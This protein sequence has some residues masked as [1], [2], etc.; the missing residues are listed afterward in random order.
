LTFLHFQQ[1]YPASKCFFAIFVVNCTMHSPDPIQETLFTLIKS[2][3][4]AHVSF[5][6][7]LSELLGIS[8]DSAYRRIRGEKELSLDELKKISDYYHISLDT[9]FNVSSDNI[10]FNSIA[11]GKE[12]YTLQEWLRIIL[13]EI[14]NIQVCKQKEIIY[15]AKD[16]PIFH[17]FEFPDLFAFKSY[18][19]NKVL[20]SAPGYEQMQFRFDFP[21]EILNMGKQ[22]LSI[23]NKVPTIELWNEETF[24]SLIRQIDFCYICN[25]FSS[26][27]DA[28]RVIDST[29]EMIKHLS[30]QAETGFRYMHGTLPEG[31]E[32]NFKL[33]CN[34]VL[35]GD[36]TIFVAKEGHLK[37]FLTYN[38]INLLVTENERFCRQVEYSLR[39]L[40]KKSTLISGTSEKERNRFFHLLQEKIN[41][42]RERIR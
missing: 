36:N 29:E 4:P 14:R 26:K 3:L 30:L 12:G 15:S 22:I 6:H 37:T 41:T 18:F 33:F 25:Y 39:T 2:R 9:L 7:E 21:E 19:W 28:L 27:E 35:L 32:G 34:E 38:V 5:V 16:I 23:Y 13:D 11:I 10:L 1:K 31:I 24:N 40:T 17:F 20:F 8:Y 42:L